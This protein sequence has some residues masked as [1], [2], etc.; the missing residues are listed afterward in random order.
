MT[1][2]PSRSENVRFG[3][4]NLHR[5]RMTTQTAQKAT[6]QFINLRE[7]F[8]EWLSYNLINFFV[9][10]FNRRLMIAKLLQVSLT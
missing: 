2:Q 1:Q 6:Y 10:L 4:W 8:R 3:C 7:L 5:K 9:R